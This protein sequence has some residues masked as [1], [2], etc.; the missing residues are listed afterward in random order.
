MG[1]DKKA[2][3]LKYVKFE[4]FRGRGAYWT[5]LPTSWFST[6][7]LRDA[8][9]LGGIAK[10]TIF[11][12]LSLYWLMGIVFILGIG[13][14][15]LRAGIGMIDFKYGLWERQNEWSG[16]NKIMNPYNHE[17]KETVREICKKLK[18]KDKFKDL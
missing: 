4:S 16:K 18:I 13:M 15:F 7:A 12:N 14:E 5:N 2:L 3:F 17:M 11:Q 1:I 8:F 6:G 10:L 9:L